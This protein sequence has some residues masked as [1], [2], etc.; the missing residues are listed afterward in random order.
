MA[1]KTKPVYRV[2]AETVSVRKCPPGSGPSHPLYNESFRW[3]KG[4]LMTEYPE[5]TNIA[6]LLQKG[7][8]EVVESPIQGRGASGRRAALGGDASP[9]V[10]EVKESPGSGTE[11]VQQGPTLGDGQTGVLTEEGSDG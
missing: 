6:S 9:A 2:L 10:D 7:A 11:P 1:G 5:Y 8:V 3:V 4:E